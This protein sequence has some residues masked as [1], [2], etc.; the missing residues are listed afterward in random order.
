MN[1]SSELGAREREVLTHIAWGAS[2]KEV[3]A[4]LGVSVYTV[5][6]TVRHIKDKLHLQKNTEISAWY[7]CTTFG[8]S[9]DLSPLKRKLGAVI[10]A[11]IIFQGELFGDFQFC[12]YRTNVRRAERREL[13]ERE[14]NEE[15]LKSTFFD[16]VS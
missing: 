1:E 3:A 15:Y 16:Y 6:N 7:F 11:I 13:R 2:Q 8:I 12:R 4:E 14:E 5:D 9:F 10:L